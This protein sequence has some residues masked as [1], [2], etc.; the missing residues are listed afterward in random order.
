MAP[1][2]AQTPFDETWLRRFGAARQPNVRL[3]CLPHA[4]GAATTFFPLQRQLPPS[5]E[6]VAVQ[7]PGR[8]DRRH[9]RPLRD[10]HALADRV[11]DV[12]APLTDLP[13]VLFGHSM[14]AV[15]GFE[16][17]AR[18]ERTGANPPI[19]LVAS[20]R[21]SPATPRVET[22]HQRDDDGLIAEITT[23]S[24][25]DPQILADPDMR[26]MILPALRADYTAVETY[27]YDRS[28]V[29]RCPVSVFTGTADPR[30]TEREASA[31]EPLTSGAFRI[32][33]FPGGHFYL[34]GAER[35]VATA[36]M[37]DVRAFSTATAT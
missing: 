26:A 7:Y 9:E 27:R 12:L 25:T 31:W 15:V 16:T 18:L 33:R 11:A 2:T 32:E 37:R 23:L 35:A 10:V 22:V 13:L 29:L 20:G 8:H 34:E 24:G 14:G 17:A 36:L 3:V 4:G 5:V 19:G 30:V 1:V 28:F 21:H 6:F